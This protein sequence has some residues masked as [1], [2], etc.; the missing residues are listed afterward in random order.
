MKQN[1]NDLTQMKKKYK[2]TNAR[3]SRLYARYFYTLL[4]DLICDDVIVVSLKLRK[5]KNTSLH[6]SLSFSLCVSLSATYALLFFFLSLL[7]TGARES[8]FELFAR[9]LANGFVKAKR[10]TRLHLSTYLS[11]FLLRNDRCRCRGCGCGCRRGGVTA[12]TVQFVFV[13]TR[14]FVT[15]RRVRFW[16]RE[17]YRRATVSRGV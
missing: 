12:R 1:T 8:A 3:S 10:R 13:A 14:R 4:Y 7:Y 2:R 6:L 16:R 11:I 17:R 9:S 5:W 15:A